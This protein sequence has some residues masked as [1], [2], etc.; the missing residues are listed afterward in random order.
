[1]KIL[2]ELNAAPVRNLKQWLD[3]KGSQW[4]DVQD[5]VGEKG[6]N[7]GCLPEIITDLGGED[8]TF[9]NRVNQSGKRRRKS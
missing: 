1:V 4:E 6:I 5:S 8:L 7:Q 3:D 2:P 9:Y